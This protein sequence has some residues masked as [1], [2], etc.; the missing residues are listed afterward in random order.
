MQNTFKSIMAENVKESVK[1]KNNLRRRIPQRSKF[2]EKTRLTFFLLSI[3]KVVPLKWSAKKQAFQRL[4]SIY[5]W[6]WI[7]F[8][9]SIL[10]VSIECSFVLFR[11]FQTA[12]LNWPISKNKDALRGTLSLFSQLSSRAVTLICS[13]IVLPTRDNA[14]F[15]NQLIAIRRRGMNG[16]NCL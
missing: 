2:M 1:I 11:M 14:N 9:A 16:R 4:L 3:L 13:V 7:V 12:I 8:I 5:S 15:V 6:Q 10:I